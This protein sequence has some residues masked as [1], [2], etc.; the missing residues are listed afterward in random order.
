MMDGTMSERNE[1]DHI[2]DIPYPKS[3][4]DSIDEWVLGV[5]DDLKNNKN[6]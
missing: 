4:T 6:K 5:A 2:I 1:E 3:L